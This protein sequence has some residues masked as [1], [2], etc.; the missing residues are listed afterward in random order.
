M[1]HSNARGFSLVELAIVCAIIA[2]LA[3]IA[4]PTLSRARLSGNEASA[5]SSLRAIASAQYM[6]SST[7][8]GGFFAPTLVVLG[9]APPSGAA[10]VSADLG[11]AAVVTKSGYTITIG[12]TAGPSPTSPASCNGVAA[13]AS[14]GGFHTLATPMPTTGTRAYGG[15]GTGTI[16]YAQQMA[17]LAMTDTTAPAGSRPI[18]Q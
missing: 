15:N 14:T 13:G 1:R 7:C 3:A 4:L 11:H 5:I 12:S 10:F 18:P 16:Y 6:Y 2:V 17:P 9:T 8:A